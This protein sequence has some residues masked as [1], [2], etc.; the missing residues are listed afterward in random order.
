MPAGEAPNV[1]HTETNG[2]GTPSARHA[3]DEAGDAIGLE[4]RLE[5]SARDAEF[6]ESLGLHI[7]HGIVGDKKEAPEVG[8]PIEVSTNAFGFVLPAL[9]V[10][11]Y[12]VRIEGVL[13]GSERRVYFTKR[14]L[15][16]AFKIPKGQ[17][18]R[19]LFQAVK[20]KYADSFSED[21][22][23][24][25]YDN[26]GILF[27]I[28]PLDLPL[29]EQMDCTLTAE[30]LASLS[31]STYASLSEVIINIK[32]VATNPMTIGDVMSYTSQVLQNNSRRLQQFL[33]V[34]TSQFMLANPDEFLS[35]GTRNAYLLNPSAHGLDAGQLTKDKEI[36][37]GCEKSVKLVEG[38][39][40][41][42][43]LDGKAVAVIDVKKTPF[44]I[45]DGTLLDKARAILN[46]EPKPIDAP[47]LRKD[48]A[49][50]VVYTKHTSKERRY[51]VENVIA[52]TAVSMTFPWTEEGREVTLLEYFVQ[53]Y[54]LEISFPRTP[55]L[56]ARLGKERKLIHLPMELCYVARNQRVTSRQQDADNIAARMIK[57]CAIAPA[58][59][60]LQI[61]KTVKALQITSSN[62]YIQAIRTKI[63][64]APLI[65]TGRRLEAPKIAYSDNVVLSPDARF[66]Y[67]KPQNAHRRPQF[68]KPAVINSWA[69]VVLPSQA[70]FVQGDIITREIL[71]RFANL[72]RSECRNRGIQIGEPVFTEFMKADVQQLRDLMK[73][74]THPDPSEGRPPLR[75][76]IFITNG[77][78]TFCHQPVKYFE[79][80]TEIVTQDLKMQT[81]VNIV[82]HNKRLT[83][84]YIVNKANVKN[85]GVNYVVIKNL[86]GQRPILKPGRLVIGLAMSYSMRRQAEEISTLPTAV[87]W[88]ANM[89]REEGE[90]IG[91]FI[92]QQSFKKDRVAVIQTIVDRVVAEY[93]HQ[94][95]C[96]EG[97]REVIIYRS[98][99]EGRFRT[100]LEE[101]LA[102][103]RATFDNMESKP[104]LTVI[105]VQKRHNLR[106]MPAKIN[107]QDRPPLQNLVPGTVV[108]RFVTH[109]TYTE[110]YLNSH[111]A[112]Q[113][114]ARTPK[115][116]VLQD[117]ANMSLEELEAMTYGLCFNHQIVSLPTSLPSPL[118]IA[119]RYAERGMSLYRQH[120]EH[121]EE[122]GAS[123]SSPSSGSSGEPHLDVERLGAH[124][125]YGSSRKL[126]NLRVNA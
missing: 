121:E 113:G 74:L 85:G 123:T 4:R 57:S 26:Q 83:L 58:E 41:A 117:D 95:R 14:S 84:E 73:T 59:R 125:S 25:F 108:D 22:E 32:H 126:K 47:R 49:E 62:P 20:L 78:I 99:D 38:P 21:E 10:W 55:L 39:M 77:E 28:A 18:C 72:F 2:N 96:P 91:D 11:Q 71:A 100:M 56:V 111:V 46:R 92:F 29:N 88:T 76:V 104:K 54:R 44:H 120:Q 105:A 109:P 33:E 45:P 69:I 19:Q 110:F 30:E 15:D 107:R 31:P 114:T 6:Y 35:Y 51:V 81:V 48:L 97:P 119:G 61:Q 7:P 5:A 50:L 9:P 115:Y 116:T 1:A 36:K 16:D 12:D 102:V 124:L 122:Q 52:D 93:K 90:F 103:L 70:E 101:D 98:G 89:T 118:Y 106:L 42:G 8:A 87:G 24:Y 65:V 27:A 79:R 53:K 86:P 67:W 13:A 68:F 23:A 17:Q 43:K 3:I 64:A 40:R 80:E 75:Y 82:Q 60:Q 66:G 112:I 37:T 34:L 94:K 63:T